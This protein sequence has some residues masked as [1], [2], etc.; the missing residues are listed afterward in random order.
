L[1]WS[2]PADASLPIWIFRVRFRWPMIARF[3]L[4]FCSTR[5]PLP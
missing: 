2:V 4:P 5:V 1:A 3:F